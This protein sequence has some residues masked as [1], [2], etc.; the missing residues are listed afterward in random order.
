MSKTF[1]MIDGHFW[2]E[3]N[4]KIIDPY[5]KDY[6]FIKKIN[7]LTGDCIYLEAE[8]LIQTVM[9]KRFN[10]VINH[11]NGT[12]TSTTEDDYK[13]FRDISEKHGKKPTVNKC[14]QN[15]VLEIANNGGN[16]K[17]GSLGWK[18][19]SGEGIHYE[20]GGEGWK[21]HQFLLN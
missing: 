15:C 9:I 19:K 5:F 16:L 6:D 1:P 3:R 13:I 11:Y 7:G 12:S 20:F 21:L 18:R 4:G 2:I 10:K 8:Q 17:F 14:F